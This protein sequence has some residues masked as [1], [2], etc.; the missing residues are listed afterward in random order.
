MADKPQ[1]LINSVHLENFILHKETFVEFTRPIMILTGSNGSGKTLFLEGLL[2]AAGIKSQ[3]IRD[4]KINNIVGD[5]GK[6]TKV[7]LRINNPIVNDERAITF[8]NEQIDGH[9]RYKGFDYLVEAK[10]RAKPTAEADLAVL[11]RKSEKKLESTRGLFVSIAGFRT[12]VIYEFTRGG[13]SNIILM[14][15]KGHRLIKKC[16]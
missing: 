9:F 7:T 6:S 3:R 11:K 1:L 5:F 13:S 16:E 4:S 8:N 15:K 14:D 10:W 2:L 12:E